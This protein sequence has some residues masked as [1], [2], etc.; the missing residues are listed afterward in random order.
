MHIDYIFGNRTV[1]VML[2]MTSELRVNMER[3]TVL[4]QS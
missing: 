3:M 2:L 1:T 4:G